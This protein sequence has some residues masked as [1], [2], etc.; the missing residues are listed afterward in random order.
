[1]TRS[2]LI[3]E[4]VRRCNLATPTAEAVVRAIFDSMAEAF[5]RGDGVELRGLGSFTLRERPAYRGRNPR[6]GD[7][8][9]VTPRRVPHF[10]PGR[11][12]RARIEALPP[13]TVDR[14]TRRG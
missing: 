1:M 8:V 12:L 7:A 11:P 2:Q 3:E 14:A 13:A 5:G 10:K 4:V 9:D 6:T